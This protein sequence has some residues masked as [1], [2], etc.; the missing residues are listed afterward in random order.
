MKNSNL[1]LIGAGKMAENYAKVL[2]ALDQPFVVIG[3][4]KYSATKFENN[5]GYKVAT[6]GLEKNI[7]KFS[8]K[9]IAI[10]AANVD[11]LFNI[12][13]K[14]LNIGVKRILLEKPGS[15][16]LKEIKLI[17][18]LAKKKKAKVLIA[19]NRRFY[20]SVN[21]IKKLSNKDGGISSVH[22]EFTEKTYLIKKLK[23]KKKIKQNW[24]IANSSHVIDLVFYL[25]GKP[26][27]INCFSKGKLSWHKRSSIFCGSGITKKNILFSYCSNWNSP[28][29]W[30]IELM[31]PKCRYLLK[32][33][34]KLKLIKFPN[35]NEKIIKFSNST[36]DEFKAGLYNQVKNFLKKNDSS[37]CSLKEQEENFRIFYKIANYR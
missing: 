25:C 4:G 18:S 24:L 7:K 31:T 19:Y 17:N 33:M 22:F 32:P 1:F 9:S 15:I 20:K 29:S 28:G 26:K 21:I 8:S 16:N 37:F 5:T 30:N 27:K 23:I 11:Q 12:T 14:L 13:K 35:L 34:E 6:G 10:V 36:E 2:C 3:R